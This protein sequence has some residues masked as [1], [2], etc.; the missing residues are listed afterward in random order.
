[1]AACDDVQE[2]LKFPF[3]Q[4]CADTGG[5]WSSQGDA[6]PP[7][8]YYEFVVRVEFPC[9]QC[10][11]CLIPSR[12]PNLP[13]YPERVRLREIFGVEIAIR[14][15]AHICRPARKFSAVR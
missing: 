10:I 12:L 13:K 14:L 6:R 3:K 5:G 7:G 11:N 1:M 9:P 15:C 2:R 8:G 4:L